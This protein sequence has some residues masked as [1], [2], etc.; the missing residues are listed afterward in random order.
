MSDA[1]SPRIGLVSPCGWGNLGDA[2]IVESAIR[3]I[4][5]RVPGVSLV[6]FTLNPG[7]TA[8][9]HG[10]PAYA[11]DRQAEDGGG[12]A[13]P[14]APGGSSPAKTRPPLPRP[15]RGAWRLLRGA[16]AELRHV[17]RA[18]RAVRGL[19][20][21][22]VCGGGQLDELWG[23]PYQH[24]YALW[25]WT[26]LA[27]LRGARVVFLSVGYGSLTTV[28]GRWFARSALG[29]ASYRSCRDQRTHG[30]VDRLGVRRAHPV[31]PDLAYGYPVRP[32]PSTAA[33]NGRLTVGVSPMAFRDP[34]A[35]PQKNAEAYAAY[36]RAVAA[37][38]TWLLGRG[39]RVTFFATAR[40]DRRTIA[41]VRVAVE[42]LGGAPR[43]DEGPLHEETVEDCLECLRG[44]DCVVV[45]RLH[46]VVLSHLAGK[47]VLA[48]SYDW[49]VDQLMMDA[50]QADLCL[51]IG[52]AT[53]D[54][55]TAAFERLEADRH[56]IAARIASRV[57]EWRAAVQRQFD[58]VFAR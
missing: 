34:R 57:E 58:E 25:K 11:L 14:A 29:L 22:V 36:V 46:S 13:G 43:P 45:S 20:V 42:A 41:D 2:A 32:P 6:A 4:R 28:V 23:G 19:R 54:A 47:P 38:V 39:H 44:V 33:A 10:I 24:P 51:G 35:W 49:K 18:Y 9:R 17:V 5:A 56:G 3:H 53:P 50:G 40:A 37:L 12:A 26:L 7:D 27:R 15:V 30:L 21:L 52:A 48:L 8:R 16:T 55:L 1:G 31:V